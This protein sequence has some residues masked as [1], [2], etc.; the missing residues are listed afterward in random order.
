MRARGGSWLSPG[1]LGPL[2]QGVVAGLSRAQPTVRRKGGR[3]REDSRLTGGDGN[4]R[5]GCVCRSSSSSEV[6]QTA[7]GNNVVPGRAS[8]VCSSGGDRAA[9]SGHATAS[10]GSLSSC[11]QQPARQGFRR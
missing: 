4:E 6:L 2:G 11:S 3:G 10:R 5:T 7:A 1:S 9:L 8:E